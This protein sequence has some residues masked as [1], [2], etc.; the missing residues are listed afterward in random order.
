MGK[1]TS[2]YYQEKTKHHIEQGD[3]PICGIK[4]IFNNYKPSLSVK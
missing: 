2:R 1:S 4:T 3:G